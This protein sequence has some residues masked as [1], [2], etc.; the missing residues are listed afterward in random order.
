MHSDSLTTGTEPGPCTY[1]VG[2]I[3]ELSLLNYTYTYKMEE[4]IGEILLLNCTYKVEVTGELS[5]LNFT[6]KLE[7]ILYI[8]I[9]GHC[10]V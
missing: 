9:C 3:H 8:Y 1:K 2:V 7:G 5:P 10:H 6:Y 4:V